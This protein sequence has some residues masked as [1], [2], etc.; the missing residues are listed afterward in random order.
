MN[1]KSKPRLFPIS[2][3][4]TVVTLGN[5]I[6]GFAAVSLML[7]AAPGSLSSERLS[8]AGMLIFAGMLLD[9]IDGGVAR[10]LKQTSQFGA[11]LDS[12]CDLI[13]FGI[14]P[15]LMI[16]HFSQDAPYEII[17]CVSLAFLLCG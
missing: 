11:E 16:L 6:C 4:P 15:A 10:L 12:L 17:W 13:S 8:Q 3:L 9:A 2:V 5:A 1:S 14:A 7:S